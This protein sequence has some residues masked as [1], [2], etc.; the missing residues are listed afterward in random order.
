MN[1][2][3]HQDRARRQTRWL[4]ILFIVAVVA[5]I[6]AVD[7]VLLLVLGFTNEQFVAGDSLTAV[8]GHNAGLLATGAG[9]TL[10]VI[11]VASLY[12]SATLRAGGG[13][14]A[15]ELGGTRVDADTRDPLRR[16]LS[17][18]VEEIAIAS[19]VPVPEI[20]VL[21][22]EEGINAFAAGFTPA[23]AAIAVTRGTL[24]KLS[25]SELQGVIAHEFAHVFNGDMRLNIRL[26]GVLF[27]ILVIA[28]LGR[29]VLHGLRFSGGGGRRG[30]GNGAAAILFIA[31]AVMLIGYV[32][33]FFGRL[34]KAAVSRQRELL[35]DASAVQ[36]TREPDGIAGALKK[37]AVTSAGS[38]L[39]VD[40][41]EVN[42][43]LFGEGRAAR[44]MATHP[45]LID[46]IRRIEP[47]FQPEELNAVAAAMER[48][49]RRAEEPPAEPAP[50]K[51]DKRGGFSL[52]PAE[53]LN[54]IGNPEFFQMLAAAA[55]AATL[56]AE[57]KAAARSTEWA[58]EVLFLALL[59]EEPSVREDQLLIV[60]RQMGEDSETQ[61]RALYAAMGTIDPQ[62][63][64]P[65][66][67]LAF[68]ALKR[69]PAPFLQR[70]LQTVDG[71]IRI[72]NRIEP[73]EYLLAK[74]LEQ[75]LWEAMN[76]GRAALAGSDRL[77]QHTE[78]A[79]RLLGVLAVQGH[80][81][82]AAVAAAYRTGLAALGLEA[83]TALPDVAEWPAAL[84]D[85]LSRL[86][87]LRPK[88]KQRLVEAMIATVSADQTVASAEAELLRAACA[89]L[90]VP[91]PLLNA[92]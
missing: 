37:I 79:R 31:L 50:K 28:L 91:L 69:R 15:R 39:H 6:V 19:G 36:F 85:A 44:L 26:I 42:H 2:F 92:G 83:D 41:E 22:Q 1:F 27:G 63:R 87:R 5:I 71:L 48:A 30:K 46:R 11:S 21:E 43:M 74:L 32:G 47:G 64:L 89:A 66:L 53:I 60:A 58:P 33:L 61:L 4:V 68:P 81:D 56:P 77:A 23:D 88:E 45:P 62:Q 59:S 40:T 54:D 76:P 86:D 38:H 73:F 51:K 3:E 90:H 52:N 16:R 18:V 70:F 75:Q 84:N 67:E 8:M 13:R 25:R 82:A 57:V 10:A 78:A 72:D 55:L 80:S 12:R 34:I 17:N 65:L 24:E 14:V 9:G 7:L 29:Q 49:S 35:A 20:Y